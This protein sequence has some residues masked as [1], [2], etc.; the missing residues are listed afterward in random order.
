MYFFSFHLEKSLEMKLLGNIQLLFHEKLKKL[1]Q[2]KT[3]HSHYL[4]AKLTM[5]KGKHV[6]LIQNLFSP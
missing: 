5:S 1:L 6:L 4:I 3:L 2:I